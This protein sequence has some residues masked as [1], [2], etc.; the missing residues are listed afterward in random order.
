MET[1]D[2]VQLHINQLT[3]DE[4]LRQ[5]LW[6]IHLE[7]TP[8]CELAS[9]LE[10]LNK[11]NERVEMMKHAIWSVFQ[12]PPSDKFQAILEKFSALEQE[13]L[14]MLALGCDISS[15]SEYNGISQVR[16]HQMIGNIR[17]SKE[18][19]DVYGTQERAQ[20]KGAVRTDSRRS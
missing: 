15:I 20:R 8:L 2:L 14:C 18:W 9:K 16:I 19:E 11:V 17:K 12:S 6:A 13:V 7:G 10:K 1:L 5:E 4:D 3:K